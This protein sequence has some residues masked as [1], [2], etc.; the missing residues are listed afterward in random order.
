MSENLK[1][2]SRHITWEQLKE[3]IQAGIPFVHRIP[4]PDGEGPALDIIVSEYGAELSLR[5]ACRNTDKAVL[6]NLE[7]LEVRQVSTVSGPMLEVKTKAQILYQEVYGFFVSVADKVQLDK[8]EPLEAIEETL[9]GWRELIK[10]QAILS[11]EAQLGLRGELYFLRGLF[12]IAG[13]EALTAW[14]G[15]ERQPHDFRIGALEFEVKTT[16][17]TSHT[18]IINGLTQLEASSDHSLYLFSMRLSPAGAHSG[19]TLPE[20]IEKTQALLNQKGRKQLDR[21]LRTHF[22]YRP[23]HADYYTLRLILADTPLLVPVDDACPRLTNDLLSSVPLRSRIYNVSYF[24]NLDGLGYA[25]D[26]EKF[27]TLMTSAILSLNQ[28]IP[29]EPKR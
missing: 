28:Q 21:I 19:T 8:I 14:I 24:A 4:S 5:I 23:E 27:K 25:E 1:K 12:K 17:S 18:H 6:S 15:P 2:E 16:R 3:R 9:D 29:N 10:T 7:E 22:N 20:E 11:E 26:S 13:N